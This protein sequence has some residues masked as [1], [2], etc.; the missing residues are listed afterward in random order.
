MQVVYAWSW[1]LFK[2]CKAL[3]NNVFVIICIKPFTTFK[4]FK[5]LNFSEHIFC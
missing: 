4:D 1:L 5:I 3:L 2:T